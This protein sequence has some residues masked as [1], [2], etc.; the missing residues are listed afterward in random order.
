M[1]LAYRV[2]G[3]CSWL[4]RPLSVSQDRGASGSIGRGKAMAESEK[5]SDEDIS[6]ED[7]SDEDVFQDEDIFDS[8][9]SG[10]DMSMS[11]SSGFITPDADVR[12]AGARA[13][14]PAANVQCNPLSCTACVRQLR[15]PH[16]QSDPFSPTQIASLSWQAGSAPLPRATRR[17][18]SWRLR[19][20]CRLSV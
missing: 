16:T 12:E 19:C 15:Q 8:G 6:D 17:S 18:L 20:A 14:A 5:E 7:I 3:G 13:A 4:K 10:S 2:R 11:P 9:S 1:R